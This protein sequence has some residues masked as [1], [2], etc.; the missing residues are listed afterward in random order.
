MSSPAQHVC[1]HCD[2]AM[3]SRRGLG[4][5]IARA[6]QDAG[7][8]AIPTQRTIRARWSE[9][10]VNLLV[11]LELTAPPE[12]RSSINEWLLERWRHSIRTLDS[13]RA[14]RR[15][16]AYRAAL[17]AQRLASSSGPPLT[18]LPTVH[19]A[20][21]SGSG[22][23]SNL[24]AEH[25]PAIGGSP[26]MAG[27]TAA[28]P[29]GE[30]SEHLGGHEGWN[31]GGSTGVSSGSVQHSPSIVPT[32][33]TGLV[34]ALVPP[35]PEITIY[36]LGSLGEEA[37]HVSNTER[38]IEGAA[39]PAE[40]TAPDSGQPAEDP[41]I[42]PACAVNSG[43]E[44]ECAGVVTPFPTYGEPATESEM[45]VVGVD[46]PLIAS[47]RAYRESTGGDTVMRG[48]VSN[49][50]E[51]RPWE[52]LL[53][54]WLCARGAGPVVAGPARRTGGGN[55][56]RPP[57][58]SRRERRAAK[59]AN[60]NR[61][62]SLWHRD[63]N[64]A[65]KEVLEGVPDRGVGFAEANAY[66]SKILGDCRGCLSAVSDRPRVLPSP[67]LLQELEL[68]TSRKNAAA[69]PDGLSSFAWKGVRNDDRLALLNAILLE[70][71]VPEILSTARTVLIPKIPSPSLPQHYRPISVNSVVARQLS[72]ILLLRMEGSVELRGDQRGFIK[73]DGCAENTQVLGAIIRD[74]RL[75]LKELH[76]ASL[77]I[78]KA[79]D[80][81][82]HQPLMD[83]LGDLLDPS[84][85]PLVMSLYVSSTTSLV[86]EGSRSDKIRIGRG[87]RQGDPLSPFLFNLAAKNILDRLSSNVGYDLRGVRVG[88]LAFA[89]DVV[90]VA[91]TPGGLRA[92][93]RDFEVGAGLFGMKVNAAK[94]VT[95][96]LVPSGKEKKIRVCT[97][98]DF[99]VDGG[100]IAALAVGQSFSYLGVRVGSTGLVSS[101]WPLAEM[102][103]RLG[104]APLK[105]SQKMEILRLH[106]LPTGI[107]PLVLGGVTCGGLTTLD[108]RVRAFIRTTLNLPRD[109]PEGFFHAKIKDGGLGV[110]SLSWHVPLLTQE[111]ISRM[112]SSGYDAARAASETQHVVRRISWATAALRKFGGVEGAGEYW[113][114]R[115]HDSVDGRDLGMCARASPS[116]SW[117]GYPGLLSN[118]TFKDLCRL[119][120]GSL[121]SAVRTSRGRRGGGCP[122]VSGWVPCDGDD[123][124]YYSGLWEDA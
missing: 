54:A 99:R 102:L 122:E 32:Q 71:T 19:E 3:R 97:D 62:Q 52:G 88:S 53:E 84:L 120:S 103:E 44:T 56:I 12:A 108:R 7:D 40:D 80:T 33:L 6:H 90:L 47:L 36:S 18:S 41:P 70:G 34:N 2:R 21:A 77:D 82:Q 93:I 74:A 61:L 49:V 111:R 83:I 37:P 66:W 116:Y 63:K 8:D 79:F 64:R 26:D 110:Q 42:G 68:T 4:G 11:Q 69:G 39:A 95:L 98:Y 112:S 124:P 9:E 89:D 46:P 81:I 117:V 43:N 96:S 31:I 60:Y 100:A 29:L 58:N 30:E 20:G 22:G 14:K 107:H 94:S 106:V 76:I 35:E 86:H 17:A 65:V 87:V 10:E 15:S 28:S 48:I 75:Q 109:T 101:E 25:L 118:G 50:L 78:S 23:S 57:P 104:A 16:S 121:P 5:H 123:R 59:R 13:L 67:V 91:S 92:R 24:L 114:R 113:A 51:G 85:V 45:T 27:A 38:D 1:P 55:Y 73:A 115:L 72:R 119:R 105:A